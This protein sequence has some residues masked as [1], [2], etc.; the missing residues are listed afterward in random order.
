MSLELG[1][2]RLSASGPSRIT[3]MRMPTEQA[4]EELV[5]AD[6]SVLGAPLLIIGR[7]VPTAYGGFIDL[8]GLDSGGTLHILELKRDKTPRDVVAQTL[9]YTSWASGLGHA[10]ISE[11]YSA[12]AV[13]AGLPLT[14]LEAAFADAF[15][16]ARSR[17]T[18]R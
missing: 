11:I 1:L 12:Y 18:R 4:L 8:L 17:C 13:K 3:S 14:S 16:E 15:D 5:A 6:A 2:W 7:Q 10:D 9:D